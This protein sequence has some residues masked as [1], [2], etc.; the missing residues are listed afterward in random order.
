MRPDELLSNFGTSWAPG[1]IGAL[2][3]QRALGAVGWLVRLSYLASCWACAVL[4][5][6]ALSRWLGTS[7]DAVANAAVIG[8]VAAFGLVI[9]DSI[10]RWLKSL[11]FPE[12]LAGLQQILGIVRGLGAK[13][14]GDDDRK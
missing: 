8:A 13:G 6:P 1:L 14:G 7:T 2:L 3:G 5:G 4:F 10:L 9:F 11:S 12:V